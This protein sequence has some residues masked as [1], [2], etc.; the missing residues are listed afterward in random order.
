M[1][2]FQ[3]DKH[4]HPVR[5]GWSV[6]GDR[7]KG[8]RDRSWHTG[9]CFGTNRKPYEV[10]K[11]TTVDFL[12]QVIEPEEARI[13]AKVEHLKAAPDIIT[14]A[15]RNG[16]ESLTKGTPEYKVE[17]GKQTRWEEEN[18]R[19]I[20]RDIK[21]LRKAIADWKPGEIVRKTKTA[22]ERVVERHLAER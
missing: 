6:Q 11:D 14:K 1:G 4:D 9:P 5:H 20:Q 22:T 16:V 10:T 12:T 17:L 7:R 8:Q 3:L 2:T 18:L 15:T 21:I 19:E 13:I